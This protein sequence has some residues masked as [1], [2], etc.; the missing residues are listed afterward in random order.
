ML[1]EPVV[2]A[3]LDDSDPGSGIRQEWRWSV[4]RV[5]GEGKAWWGICTNRHRHGAKAMLDARRKSRQVDSSDMGRDVRYSR[6][7]V[8]DGW[9]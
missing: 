7:V 1:R 5:S 4:E 6:G 2:V 3:Q 9:E 8:R